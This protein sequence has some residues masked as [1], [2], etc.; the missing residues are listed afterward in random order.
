MTIYH[1]RLS[2]AAQVS[3][4]ATP[5]LRGLMTVSL[6]ICMALWCARVQAQAAKP[7]PSAPH[8]PVSQLIDQMTL[9]EKIQGLHTN[10]NDGH[11]VTG[12]PRLG[13]PL[14]N[15]TNGPAGAGNGGVGHRGPATA[16][17]SPIALAATWDV[18][19]AN[20]YGGIVA[21]EAKVQ[22]NQVVF[23]PDINIA[24]TPQGGRTFEGFGEDPYLT[25]LMGVAESKGIQS[26][27][28]I[29]EVKH[30]AANN[31]ENARTTINE[32]IDERTLREI[33]LPAWEAAVKQAGIG[34]VMCSYNKVNGQ[35]VCANEALLRH[36][37]KQEWGFTGFVASDFGAVHD[38]LPY[39]NAGLDLEMPSKYFAA[40][41]Q[42][43]ATKGEV[44]VA[45]INEKLYRRYSTMKRL[46]IWSNPAP[47]QEVPAQPNGKKARTIAAAGMVLLKNDHNLLPLNP[48]QISSIAVIGPRAGAASTG[49]GGS[50]W[51]PP[52]YTVAP[53]DGIQNRAGDGVHVTYSD[54]TDIPAAADAARSANVAILMLGD[55]DEEGVD[56]LI[57]LRGNQNDLAT[58]VIAANPKTIVVLKTGSAVLLPWA[59]K[60]AAI[61]EA[62]Y[63]GEE[64]GNA[65]ADILFGDAN[66][67][68]RLPL[69][70]P[71]SLKDLPTNSPAQYPGV[72]GT[73]TY[74]EGVFVGYR[75]Y[76]QR[77]IT[78]AYPFGYGLSYTTFAYKNLAV[79]P[80]RI[81]LGANSSQTVSVDFD[82]INDGKRQGA[83]VAQLYLGIPG[84]AVPEPP[85]ALKGFAKLPLEP[86]QTRHVHLTLDARAF[87]YWDTTSHGWK[88]AP[89]QYKIMVGSSSRDIRLNGQLT[90][91]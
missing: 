4:P 12:V 34:A 77:N 83:E 27:G 70:F 30:Y 55:K 84:T 64:D 16:L 76:D 13:I 53:V 33:Y 22:A 10:P 40:P 2:K 17:P 50:S 43:A 1:A 8:D 56:Q 81:S 79:S 89:G 60:A 3:A 5:V 20:A 19:Y 69:T 74:S 14:L 48:S 24:R 15:M 32:I 9:D 86:G 75:H 82:I 45:A 90:I 85:K 72:D 36:I 88:I 65:V 58:A 23:G 78:P 25:S 18:N 63:P 31:Q 68:G 61:L 71:A 54:G 6:L 59:H 57:T 42:E 91:D 87:S 73:A 11:S 35:Y 7:S 80:A 28:L 44:S 67:S 62:W 47:Q 38:T 37:L 49:G 29:A 26:Q 46:G 41:L 21:S 52:L 39:F 66:P 51:V